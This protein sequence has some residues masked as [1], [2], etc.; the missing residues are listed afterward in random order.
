MAG[1][2]GILWRGGVFN[3]VRVEAAGGIPK[4]IDIDIFNESLLR[5][6]VKVERLQALQKVVKDNGKVVRTPTLNHKKVYGP[7]QLTVDS[8]SI[9]LKTKNKENT[10]I[11][12]P[13]STK[14]NSIQDQIYAT[15]ILN[16][17][18]SY[19]SEARYTFQGAFQHK[20]LPEYS[21]K[22]LDMQQATAPC[23]FIVEGARHERSGKG[24]KANTIGKPTTSKTTSFFA[25][26]RSIND[27][28]TSSDSIWTASECG[29]RR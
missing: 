18:V 10:V 3:I 8:R 28:T 7:I 24:K 16:P 17:E 25:K 21:L 14:G 23:K 11:M 22:Y 4:D 13:R 19:V 26:K 1:A 12:L 20:Q 5:D 15:Q 9:H 2:G 6:P 27:L 29:N